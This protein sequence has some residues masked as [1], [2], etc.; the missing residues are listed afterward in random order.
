MRSKPGTSSLR[1]ILCMDEVFGYMPPVAEP[2]SKKAFLTLLKQACAF[3]LGLVLAP[4]SPVDLD[5][6]GLGNVGT[7]LLGRLQTERDKERLLDGLQGAGGGSL[8]RGGLDGMLSQLGKR[9]FL[10]H[11]VHEDG[12][13]VFQTR[14]TLSY[15][16]GPP[17]RPEIK[18]MMD[19]RKAGGAAAVAAGPGP[20]PGSVRAGAPGPGEAGSAP[21]LPPDVSQRFLPVRAKP[22]GILYRPG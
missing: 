20:A 11:D 4:Q 10:L 13:V 15:L 8:D 14:W 18:R 2:P 16:R 19:P 22:A 5:Y 17:T 1:A 6:K 21:V 12:P 3:G 7:W 9:V